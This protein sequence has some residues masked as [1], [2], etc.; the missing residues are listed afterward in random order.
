MWSRDIT[1]SPCIYTRIGAWHLPRQYNSGDIENR[2]VGLPTL[3]DTECLITRL[4]RG[5][6][7][8]ASRCKH[9]DPC[10]PLPSEGKGGVVTLFSLRHYI[11][12]KSSLQLPCPL[13]Y[14]YQFQRE[15]EKIEILV[16]I[17]IRER[18]LITTSNRNLLETSDSALPTRQIHDY[19]DASS[20]KDSTCRLRLS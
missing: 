20:D 9:L 7:H 15:V 19:T 17:T 13:S 10:S 6:G 14:L 2:A 8:C 4:W 5:R 1:L 12:H 3:S 16:S 11:V 18:V